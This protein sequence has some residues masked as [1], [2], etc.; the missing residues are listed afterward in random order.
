MS[1]W[2]PLL[3]LLSWCPVFQSNHCNWLRLR[4]N[5]IQMSCRGLI[6]HPKEPGV[7]VTKV[8]FVNFSVSKIFDLAKVPVRFFESH[9][10]L[11]DVTTAKLRW[12][13]CSIWVKST[14]TK[15]QRSA[16]RVRISG[17]ALC[18]TLGF[19]LLSGRTSYHKI[20]WS[21]KATRFGFKLFQSLWNLTGN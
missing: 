2:W 10:Y 14:S 21:L 15:T 18:G 17:D 8:L 6:I 4:V 1:P 12:H 19:Y 13:L 5:D 3:S 16:K 20:L 7:W 9:S 11:T